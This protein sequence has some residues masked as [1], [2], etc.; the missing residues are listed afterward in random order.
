MIKKAKI[1]LILLAGK[2][3]KMSVFEKTKHEFAFNGVCPP[4]IATRQKKMK[5]SLIYKDF[6]APPAGIEPTT[7]P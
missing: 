6:L 4:A 2:S 1:L 7:C 5:K 3:E